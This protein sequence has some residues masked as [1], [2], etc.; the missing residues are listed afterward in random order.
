ML[1]R[2]IEEKVWR[3]GGLR[4]GIKEEGCSW[5]LELAMLVMTICYVAGGDSAEDVIL[6]FFRSIDYLKKTI[7]R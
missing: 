2:A 7:Q 1:A 5:N 3:K 6:P 4:D